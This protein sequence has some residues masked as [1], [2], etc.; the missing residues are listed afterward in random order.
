MQ[1]FFFADSLVLIVLY[2]IVVYL[3]WDTILDNLNNLWT[4]FF[5]NVVEDDIPQF[6]DTFPSSV[7]SDQERR[8]RT[9][10]SSPSCYFRA[11]WLVDYDALVQGLSRA[12]WLVDYDA[13]V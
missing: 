4:I 8:R 12:P 7:E 6:H 1:K 10:M 5:N 9:F 13:F 2:Q 11:L 3:K